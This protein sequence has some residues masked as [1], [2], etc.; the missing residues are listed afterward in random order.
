MNLTDYDQV[1]EVAQ[2][3]RD[4]INSVIWSNRSPYPRVHLNE[5]LRINRRTDM[6]FLVAAV[7]AMSRMAT[8]FRRLWFYSLGD[9]FRNRGYDLG[10]AAFEDYDGIIFQ[11][12]MNMAREIVRIIRRSFEG[13][14]PIRD[15]FQGTE[16]QHVMLYHDLLQR[17]TN[18]L[19]HTFYPPPRP[20]TTGVSDFFF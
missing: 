3:F 1:S 4:G 9:S 16:L 14:V 5:L 12:N 19:A 6:G 11:R 17:Y 2:E 20:S 13:P 18:H 15:G 10:G 7:E 8:D